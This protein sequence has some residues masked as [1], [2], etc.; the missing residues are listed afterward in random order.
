MTII[1]CI[2]SNMSDKDNKRAR[3]RYMWRRALVKLLHICEKQNGN[4]TLTRCADSNA[5]CVINFSRAHK[6][7]S[8]RKI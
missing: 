8:L 2:Y 4:T 7:W 1:V 5:K 3:D 6:K